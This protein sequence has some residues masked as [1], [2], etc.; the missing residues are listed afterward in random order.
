ANVLGTALLLGGVAFVVASGA[1]GRGGHLPEL[2]V[3]RAEA[4]TR[5][6]GRESAFFFHATR[7]V[8]SLGS[9]DRKVDEELALSL[10]VNGVSR[11]LAIGH[12]DLRAAEKGAFA[13]A[14]PIALGGEEAGALFDLRLDAQTGALVT[15]L[16]VP[17]R[18]QLTAPHAIA[19][20]IETE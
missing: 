3:R 6:G 15:E 10:V 1:P 2:G 4:G 18:G 14:I 9:A 11:P 7:G 5:L 16:H 8:L 13:A 20:R 17:P 12:Q 19:L